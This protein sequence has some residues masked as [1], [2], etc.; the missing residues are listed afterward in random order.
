[1]IVASV[2]L[3]SCLM[4]TEISGT[5]TLRWVLRPVSIAMSLTRMTFQGQYGFMEI[6]DKQDAE[7]AIKDIN[8]KNFNGGQIRVRGDFFSNNSEENTCFYLFSN[9][10]SK[11]LVNYLPL[12]E[13]EFSNAYSGDRRGGGGSGH[14]RGRDFDTDRGGRWHFPPIW[15]IFEVNIYRRVS[16]GKFRRT[17]YRLVVKNISSQTS[18]QVTRKIEHH[19]IESSKKW[20]RFYRNWAFVVI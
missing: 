8:G 1:M 19:T 11:L 9:F 14:S 10:S 17:N 16:D 20:S 5:S 7:D 4:A 12:I 13:V 15:N 2:T 18:W 6:D 3:R